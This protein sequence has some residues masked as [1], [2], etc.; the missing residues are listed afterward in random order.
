MLIVL[1]V[2]DFILGARFLAY[3]RKKHPELWQNLGGP[4]LFINNSI[5]IGVRMRSFI[6][7]KEYL[8]VNDV[9]LIKK[10]T[11]L[12]YYSHIYIF[13]FIMAISLFLIAIILKI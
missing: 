10:A 13:V 5:K 7:N 4:T 2:G 9:Q 6:K 3:L 1:G 8:K 11:F 12:R